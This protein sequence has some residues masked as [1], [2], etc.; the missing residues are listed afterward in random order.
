MSR[1]WKFRAND[2][3]VVNLIDTHVIPALMRN[4]LNGKNGEIS[5]HVIVNNFTPSIDDIKTIADNIKHGYIQ[6]ELK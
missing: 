1:W 3:S 6:G 4:E 5:W 2:E